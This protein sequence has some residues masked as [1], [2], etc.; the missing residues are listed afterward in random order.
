MKMKMK[1]TKINL[2]IGFS[3]LQFVL[4]AEGTC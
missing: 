3:I 2:K 4:I 1:N